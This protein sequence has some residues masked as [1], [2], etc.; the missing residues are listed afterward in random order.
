MTVKEWESHEAVRLMNSLDPTIWVPD[1]AMTDKE[2]EEHPRWETTEGYLKTITM[3][4]AWANMWHN[5]TDKNKKV[6]TKLPNFDA[7]IFEQIT[8][9]KI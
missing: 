2:K 1:H 6:F 9:I 7:T 5:L 8:G 3:K 4:E